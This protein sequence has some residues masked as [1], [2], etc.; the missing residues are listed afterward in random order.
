M[1]NIL[2]IQ[3]S[4]RGDESASLTL[5][6]ELIRTLETH[7]ENTTVATRDFSQ[8]PPSHV[9]GQQ[10]GAFFTPLDH[11]SESQKAALA[12]SDRY[13]KHLKSCDILVISYPVWNFLVPSGLKAWLDHIIRP[14][15]TFEYRDHAPEGLLTGK[16]VYLVAARGG[17]YPERLDSS[18]TA[19]NDYSIHY[20]KTVLTYIGMNDI[21]VFKADGLANPA[22]RNEVLASAVRCIQLAPN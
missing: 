19:F 10:I 20:L 17:T 22:T 12:E 3:N 2:H 18:P 13:I 11:Q 5:A 1:K 6:G 14:G 7:H 15:V 4:P 21:T 16:K 9:T 8:Q